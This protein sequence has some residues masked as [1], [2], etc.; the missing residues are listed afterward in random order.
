MTI[1]HTLDSVNKLLWPHQ[2]K[3]IH[4]TGQE[5]AQ[6]HTSVC[7]VMATGCHRAGQLVLM[8][9]ATLRRIEDIRTGDLLMG[10]DSTPRK[11]LALCRGRDL[12]YEIVPVKGEPFVVNGDHM[13]SLV[14]TADSRNP[15]GGIIDVTVREWCSWSKSRKHLYKLFRTGFDGEERA[16]PIDP[17]FLGV[18][19]GDG[20]MCNGQI[21]VSKPDP[22]IFEACLREASSRGATITTR[23]RSA[24]NPTH[25][26]GRGDGSLLRALADLRLLGTRSHD[27]FVPQIYKSAS[28]AQRRHLLAGLLDTDG[29]LGRAGFDY[30]S[31]SEALAR[32]VAFLARS[33]DLAAYIKPC[34][35]A[36]QTGAVGDYWRVSISGDCSQLPLRI[37]RKKSAPRGQK[38]S[39]LRTGFSVRELGVEDY[40][41]VQIDGDHRYLLGDFTV[42]HNSGKTRTGGGMCVRHLLKKPDGKILWTAHREELV[43]QAFDDLSDWGLQCGVIQS[44]PTR[45][46]NPHR[47]VQIASTQTLLARG[48]IPDATMV[49]LDE[50]HHYV[51]NEWV[52]LVMPYRERKIPIIGL[53]ATPIRVDGRGYEGIM[54]ALVC[55]I[56]MREL[57]DQGFLVD[58]TLHA[59]PE[60]LRND[61]IAQD[62]VKAYIELAAGRKAIVFAANKKAATKYRDDFRAA[63]IA[64][65]AVFGDTGTDERRRILDGYKEGKIQ[66]LTNVGVLTEGFDDKPTSCVILARSVGSLSLYLQMCGRALR[67]SDETGKRDA[68]VIDLHGSC[69]IHGEPA[70]DREWTL[71]GD[72]IKHRK[73]EEKFSVRMCVVCKVVLDDPS[74]TVC[75]LCYYARPEAVPP[76][77]ANVQLVRYAAKLRETPE[78]KRMYFEKLKGIARARGYS[79][80]QPHQKYKAI[81]GERPPREWW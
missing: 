2:R 20:C 73:D 35:K 68:I 16:L 39:V 24:N 43:G 67:K 50:M 48:M 55:P 62:P 10:S 56:S 65:E 37:E 52:K 11:V 17:Y 71:E 29:S 18:L 72:G 9:D 47:P 22:E 59:P 7:I 75:D 13:L 79:K 63:G 41:G 66:V 27:K 4:L 53:T 34:R 69:R 57:I 38:K 46:Y 70:D 74:A 61:Q 64:C 45:T 54:D 40:F 19:L 21:S 78:Q 32:D 30:V 51:S 14:R 6:G 77:V 26:F 23:Y 81:Y 36:C 58:Y 76:E 31:K 1:P 33:L 5:F 15:G 12:M 25:S 8:A 28:R 42:T 80:W 49:V 44:K 3:A 60:K